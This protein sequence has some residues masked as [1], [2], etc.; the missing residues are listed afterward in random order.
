MALKGFAGIPSHPELSGNGGGGEG[1]GRWGE[2]LEWNQ[3]GS[4]I[5]ASG[6][7]K[8]PV[9][10]KD[11]RFKEAQI[12]GALCLQSIPTYPPLK[13]LQLAIPSL[14]AKFKGMPGNSVS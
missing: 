14:G 1:E 2:G 13:K 3:A 9:H 11:H 6:R 5:L 4:F 7:C 8:V 12:V 10:K